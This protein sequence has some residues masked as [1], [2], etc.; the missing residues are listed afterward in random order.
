MLK[1]IY[2]Q[3]LLALMIMGVLNVLVMSTLYFQQ[4]QVLIEQSNLQRKSYVQDYLRSALE[5][6]L[7]SAE[8]VVSHLKDLVDDTFVKTTAPEINAQI[9]ESFLVK[10]APEVSRLAQNHKGS[11]T[12]YIYF[13]PDLNSRAM[14]VYYADQN[15]DGIVEP[16]QRLQAAYFNASDAKNPEKA[17]WFGAINSADAFWSAPY[18]WTFDNGQTK[19]FVSLTRAIYVDNRLLAVV[20]TDLSLDYLTQ[21]LSHTKALTGGNPY[22]FSADNNAIY[23]PETFTELSLKNAIDSPSA[24]ERL[25]IPLHNQWELG[26]LTPTSVVQLTYHAFLKW[27]ITSALIVILQAITLAAIVSHYL[28]MPLREIGKSI[29]DTSNLQYGLKLPDNIVNRNDE[30]GSVA[31][32]LMSMSKSILNHLNTIESQRQTLQYIHQRDDL[33]HLPNKEFLHFQSKPLEIRM[34]N[35]RHLVILLNIDNFRVLNG[36]LGSSLCDRILIEISKRLSAIQPKPM[37]IARTSGD[38]FTLIYTLEGNESSAL[39]PDAFIL[40]LQAIINGVYILGTEDIH[41]SISMGISIYPDHGLH[42]D[43][44]IK[45]AAIA[46][47]QVKNHN[48]SSFSFYDPRISEVTTEQFEML[49]KLRDA[50]ATA[51]MELFYQPQIHAPS[52]RCIGAEA[53]LRWKV[54]GAYVPPVFFIPLAEESKLII[55]LGDIVIQKAFGFAQR[56]EQLNHPIKISIN[57]SSEQLT[58]DHLYR[59][60]LDASQ[61]YSVKPSAIA[62]EITESLIVNGQ[63]SAL[64]V[65]KSLGDLG[66]DIAIDDFGTGYSSL[67]YLKSIPFNTLKLDR[68]FIKDYPVTDDGMIAK[69]ILSLGRDLGATLIAE[70]ME[71]ASQRDFL[72]ACGCDIMQGYFYSKPLSETEFIEYIKKNHEA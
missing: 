24:Y 38:E 7:Y 62:L 61:H 53:L 21:L 23:V 59:E 12:A 29:S 9:I 10:V 45:N 58:W 27:L 51:D 40:R 19:T 56:L 34:H 44:L 66:F 72:Q 47:N 13:N 25:T 6:P 1:S 54:D 15:G 48:K 36:M 17:W 2:N 63:K 30:I 35:Q 3:L 70:G 33:T 4:G 43:V 32:S 49:K 28:S 39:D 8:K 57:I 22:L 71:D 18:D 55:P 26:L 69:M 11:L 14:D 31:K 41:L 68:M 50:I 60:L 20:G 64:E 67:S 65:L 52:G 37:L 16:Q 46:L 5:E 42:L